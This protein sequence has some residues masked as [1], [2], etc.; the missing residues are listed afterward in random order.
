MYGIVVVT[1][2]IFTGAQLPGRALRVL[3]VKAALFTVPLAL[4][5]SVWGAT[6]VFAGIAVS[7]LLGYAYAAWAMKRVLSARDSELG[8]V[9]LID[10][11]LETI[12]ITGLSL[13]R[14]PS[15]GPD[16]GAAE[17]E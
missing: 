11:Y 6:G 2:A 14:M 12:S 5:G 10:E 17:L 3:I 7:N 15:T 13:H 1:A 16:E 9:R 4:L 8:T